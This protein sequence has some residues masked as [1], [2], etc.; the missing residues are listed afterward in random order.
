MKI[1]KEAP[2]WK[3]KIK[4]G[5]KEWEYGCGALLEIEQNDISVREEIDLEGDPCN[6]FEVKC[7]CC[8]KKIELSKGEIPVKIKMNLL[9]G[10]S[11]RSMRKRLF[12]EE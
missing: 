1:L 12:Y 2:V 7:P 4:C 8:G 5:E 10:A 3:K 11:N 6:Y 9:A